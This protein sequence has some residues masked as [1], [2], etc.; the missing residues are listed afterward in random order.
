[1]AGWALASNGGV[2]RPS[3][4]RER[5][6]A[7]AT[8]LFAR[9]GVHSVGVN[10]IWQHADVAKSTLYQH[11]RSKDDLV[12]EVLRRHDETWCAQLRL[13]AEVATDPDGT[14]L[15]IFELLDADFRD[16]DYRGNEFLNVSAEYPDQDHPVRQAIRA[17]KI[18]LLDYL[19]QLAADAGFTAP[20]KAAAAVLMLAD[21]AICARVTR[22]DTDA[23]KE[24]R[25]TA[26]LVL[27]AMPRT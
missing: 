20:G 8:E 9:S 11:F 13:S 22:N 1:M 10:E 26:M 2:T 3:A 4:S 18:H 17:H 19:T 7:A 23:A 21:G 15:A 16:T 14:L 6:I 5:L 25:T 12:V 24:A 27:K